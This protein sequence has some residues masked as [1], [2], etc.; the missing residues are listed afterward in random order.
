MKK[1]NKEGALC[2][3]R[4]VKGH[5][6]D[7]K[8]IRVWH[9]NSATDSDI[10]WNGIFETN[11]YA[12]TMP[13]RQFCSPDII[14]MYRYIE[15]SLSTKKGRVGVAFMGNK[16]AKY[17]NQLKHIFESWKDVTMSCM[18]FLNYQWL[19][20]SVKQS[21]IAKG[22]KDAQQNNQKA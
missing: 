21:D 10:R 8:S 18:S 16:C 15:Y 5:P 17:L 12:H 3:Q 19:S 14:Y 2:M 13:C 1:T 6:V 20:P 9:V 22:L 11:R 4:I 7:R